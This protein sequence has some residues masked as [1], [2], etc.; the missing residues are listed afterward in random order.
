MP[1]TEELMA[2]EDGRSDYRQISTAAIVGLLFGAMGSLALAHLGLI[3]VPLAAVWFNMWALR[4]IRR[5]TPQPLGRTASLA[6]LALALIFTI[7]APLNSLA[8]RYSERARAIEVARH[9]FVAL[10]EKSPEVAHQ[11]SLPTWMRIAGGESITSRY[12]QASSHRSLDEY[13]SRPVVRSLLDLGKSAHVKYVRNLSIESNDELKTIVDVYSITVGH[14]Q[15]ATT[16]FLTLTVKVRLDRL[17][18]TWSWEVA[19][20]QR[21]DRP[22]GG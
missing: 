19:D 21:I 11:L 20:A 7:A 6:G 17:R 8:E 5:Q 3:V 10:R 2:I 22:V 12:D 4:H 14:G 16:F 1:T 18:Q 13:A 9:W 15:Q